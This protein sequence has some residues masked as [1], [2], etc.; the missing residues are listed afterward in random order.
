[1]NGPLVH[2]LL[3]LVASLVIVLIGTLFAESDDSAARRE[4]PRRLIK[5]LVGCSIVLGI[6]LVCEHTLA[7]I[8]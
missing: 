5:F 3:F 6:M 8:H 2:L 4:F 1:M 7:S